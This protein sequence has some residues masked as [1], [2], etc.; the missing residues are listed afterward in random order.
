MILNGFGR[1]RTKLYRSI[2]LVGRWSM[3]DIFMIAILA[4]LVNLGNIALIEPGAGAL[5]FAAVVI[6]TMLASHRFDPKLIWDSQKK[7]DQ[8]RELM[9]V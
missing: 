8:D 9:R 2:E 4:S 6:L 1:N 7:A 5:C 3:V